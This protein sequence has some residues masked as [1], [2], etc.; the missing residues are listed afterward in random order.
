MFIK[1]AEEKYKDL[2]KFAYVCL[3]DYIEKEISLFSLS[4]KNSKNLTI[5]GELFEEASEISEDI[6]K[7]RAEL[8]QFFERAGKM[9]NFILQQSRTC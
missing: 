7:L 2:G 4:I 3:L 9:K 6:V 5:Y 8:N 1:L